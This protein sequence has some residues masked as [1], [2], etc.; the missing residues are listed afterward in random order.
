MVNM[1][2]RT[3]NRMLHERCSPLSSSY[4]SEVSNTEG[5]SS[6]E[7]AKSSWT[8]DVAELAAGGL[9]GCGSYEAFKIV[10]TVPSCACVNLSGS[11]EETRQTPLVQKTAED[12]SAITESRL[13]LG[14]GGTG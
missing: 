4:C 12:V 14:T 7:T 5:P 8:D 9:T 10:G 2:R 3:A 6:S 1:T 13:D 11:L